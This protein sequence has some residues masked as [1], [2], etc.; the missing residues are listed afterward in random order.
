[1]KNRLL[2]VADAYGL[3]SYAPR[4]R[5]LC[6]YLHEYGWQIE[7]VTE[8]FAPL[9]FA[10]D[11]PIREVAIYKGWDWAIKAIWSLL[12]DWKNRYFSRQIRKIYHDR[13]F[14]AVFCTTFSTFPLRAAMDIA[15]E[16]QIPLHV[17]IRDL[18]EQIPGAQY[19]HHRAW[20]TRPLRNWY[21]Q[22]N[23]R[24]RNRVLR[25][26]DQITTISPWHK[27]FIQT[28]NKNVHLVYNGYDPKQ[29]YPQNEVTE[30]FRIGYIGKIYEFQSTALIEQVVDEIGKEDILLDW[31]RPDYQP[32]DI[33]EVGDAIRKCSI[34]L[35]LTNPQAHGMMTTKFYE[36]LG[37]EKP[38]L[39]IPSDNGCLAQVIAETNAG[40]ASGDKEEIKAFILEKYA[41]WKQNGFT[42]QAVR[43][44]EAFSR[45]KQAQEIEQLLQ[46]LCQK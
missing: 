41:E 29:F 36:A 22:V 7:V 15:R 28:M 21:K 33:M 34:M 40:L 37:C 23:I 2:I 4:L 1:M 6:E 42:H 11:Y 27:N 17:D 3:P 5:S 18:D 24:R 46:S 16:K 30:T 45:R 26:A 9:S 8:P 32:I 25:E 31:H 38:V 20:W 35:V 43:G 13:E 44:K 12:T 10:H 14:D 19:Q 39:C